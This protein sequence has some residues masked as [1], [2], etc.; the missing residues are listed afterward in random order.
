MRCRVIQDDASYRVHSQVHLRVEGIEKYLASGM[1]RGIGPVY[2]KKL[3]RAFGDKVFDVIEADGELDTIVAAVPPM[4]GAEYLTAAVL[5]NLWRGMDAA[6]DAQ[7]A[8]NVIGESILLSAIHGEARNRDCRNVDHRRAER[9]I[10]DQAAMLGKVVMVGAEPGQVLR[11]KTVF[12]A[13][14]IASNQT[15]A[16]IE[17]ML[18]SGEWNQNVLRLFLCFLS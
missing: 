15:V 18:K 9:M 3:L 7:L 13:A 12:A 8:D 5:A 1:I 2:A 11:R 4:I 10:P 14:R 17:Y 16:I 6:F